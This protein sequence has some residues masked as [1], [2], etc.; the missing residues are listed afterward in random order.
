MSADT[1]LRCKTCKEY[2]TGRDFG[3]PEI[4]ARFLNDHLNHDLMSWSEYADF[5][6]EEEGQIWLEAK[7]VTE[8]TQS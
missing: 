6:S 5:D 8:I 1:E 7:D 4:I 2:I 3:Q